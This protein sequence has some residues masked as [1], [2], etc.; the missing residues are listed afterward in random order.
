MAGSVQPGSTAPERSVGVTQ[1]FPELALDGALALEEGGRCLLDPLRV[2]LAADR[3]LRC[4]IN[5]FEIRVG[6]K[7]DTWIERLRW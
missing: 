6:E 4:G 5:R 3:S 2:R 7:G 1:R